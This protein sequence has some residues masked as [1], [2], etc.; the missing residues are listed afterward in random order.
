ME[1]APPV[2]LVFGHDTE[3]DTGSDNWIGASDH[4]AFHARGI[5]FLYFGVADHPDYHR[6]TD[7][8]ETLNP[9]FLE[10]AARTVFRVVAHLDGVLAGRRP[11]G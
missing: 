6:P 2:F 9:A 5:P 4:G 1:P 8:T 3:A 11:G 10:G 7:D